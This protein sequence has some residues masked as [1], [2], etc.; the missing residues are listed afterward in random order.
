M[1]DVLNYK[2]SNVKS[3]KREEIL[4]K[5]MDIFINEGIYAPTMKEIAKKCGVSLRSLYY[6]YQNKEDL[7]V[8]IQ[9]L[10]M[11][12]YNNSVYKNYDGNK[13]AHEL[14]SEIIY[15]QVDM[16]QSNAKL[17]KYITVFD[18]YFINSYPNDKYVNYLEKMLVESL[19]D[20]L[21]EKAR[22]DNTIELHG[23][24]PT[25]IFASTA[26]CI[27]GYAQKIIYREKAMLTEKRETKGDLNVLAN[28]LV[29]ALKKR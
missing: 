3:K 2:E 19:Y 20:E 14:M 1:I 12:E 27:L 15:R 22:T 11:H 13:S 24:D 23:A 18:Y 5:S 10:C 25:V 9:L 7:A 17:I 6:Y 26:Q 21:I 29:C 8:D 4:K 16:L 28:M